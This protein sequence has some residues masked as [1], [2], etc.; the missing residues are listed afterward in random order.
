VKRVFVDSG[1]FFAL[2]AA[3][4]RFHDH[5]RSPF[6]RADAERWRLVTTNAVV[7]ETYALLL[8]RSRGGRGSALAFLDIVGDDAYQVERVRKPDEERAIALL[9]AHED[10][11]YSLCDALSFV[12][13]ERLRIREA[14]AF[15]RHFRAYGRF[16]IL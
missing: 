13:M 6:A 8:A 11:S 14:I 5:A 16:T 7:V 2:L 15:D 4:D 9:R 10:K 1:G 3:E 12:V